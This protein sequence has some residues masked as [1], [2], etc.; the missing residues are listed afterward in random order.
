MFA[1]PSLLTVFAAGAVCSATLFNGS[2]QAQSISFTCAFSTD[3]MPTTFAQTSDGNVPVFQWKSNYFRAPYTPMQRCIEVTDRM[4]SFHGRGMLENITSG[5]VNNQPVLC[6][7]TRCD[8]RGS[9]V[10]I[11]LRPDQNPHQVL[12]EL[13]S[14]RAG[15][16]G[17]SYQLTGGSTTNQNSV[18]SVLKKNSDGSVTLNLNRYLNSA[19]PQPMKPPTSPTT[20]GMVP[21]YSSPTNSAPSRR[22]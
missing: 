6:A 1:K 8:A 7:G 14:N 16:G 19:T 13:D 22:W 20:P 5:R 15:A 21:S 3:N 11:T 17:P 4:N 2:S 12:Q 18:S 10:L 9:N